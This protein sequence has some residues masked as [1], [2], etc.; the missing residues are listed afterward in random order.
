MMTTGSRAVAI[1]LGLI[2]ICGIL[3]CSDA[4]KSMVGDESSASDR[5]S[6]E[7]TSALKLAEE[8]GAM[9]LNLQEGQTSAQVALSGFVK[10]PE[11]FPED[12]PLIEGL[13]VMVASHDDGFYSLNGLVEKPGAVLE[14][15]YRAEPV[16]RGWTMLNP[17][18]AMV[19]Q[20]PFTIINYSK[21][22]R[23]LRVSIFPDEGKASLTLQ[24]DVM[25]S[26]W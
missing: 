9:T 7:Q 5:P 12:I 11:G 24:T 2:W 15:F 14:A 25:D 8:D 17:N 20:N 19:G 21:G 16:E 26:T 22:D 3:A 6:S 13:H 10:V 18:P 23:H 1:C 4:E